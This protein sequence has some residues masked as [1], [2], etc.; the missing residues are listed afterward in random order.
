[1]R[2]SIESDPKN[3]RE[4][5]FSLND[6]K[7]YGFVVHR[8]TTHRERRKRENFWLFVSFLFFFWFVQW[9]SKHFILLIC[10][11][12]SRLCLF[13]WNQ[14]E[15]FPCDEIY[16]K[17]FKTTSKNCFRRFFSFFNAFFYVFFSLSMCLLLRSDGMLKSNWN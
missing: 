16:T 10:K 11:K 14:F 13:R 7:W 5:T 6:F 12:A 3:A 4:R 1:M 15:Q 2:S 9:I 17:K 8:H